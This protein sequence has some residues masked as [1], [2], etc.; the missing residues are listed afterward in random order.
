MPN[1]SHQFWSD[2]TNFVE[3]NEFGECVDVEENYFYQY[4]FNNSMLISKNLLTLDPL[5]TYLC[6][7]KE[8]KLINKQINTKA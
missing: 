7:P 3:Q 6:R 8:I 5:L 1:W 4:K 2:T